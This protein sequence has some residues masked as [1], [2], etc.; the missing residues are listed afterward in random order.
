MKFCFLNCNFAAKLLLFS[1]KKYTVIDTPQVFNF[2][3]VESDF[4]DK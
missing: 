3:K 2:I 1:K 4:R